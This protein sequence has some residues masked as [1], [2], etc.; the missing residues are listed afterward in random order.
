MNV[1]LCVACGRRPTGPG[2]P[3]P[4]YEGDHCDGIEPG[5][6]VRSA[7]RRGAGPEAAP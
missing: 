5:G 4:P 3:F 1:L 6:P 2:A 7:G